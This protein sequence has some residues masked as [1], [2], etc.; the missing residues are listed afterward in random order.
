MIWSALYLDFTEVGRTTIAGVQGRYYLPLLFPLFSMFLPVKLRT[1]WNE[2][3]YD[4]AVFAVIACIEFKTI[5]DCVL[6]PFN[7]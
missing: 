5:Y 7:I 6:V 1:L 3:K 2:R 4:L